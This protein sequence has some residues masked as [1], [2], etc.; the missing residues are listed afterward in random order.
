MKRKARLPLRWVVYLLLVTLLATGVSLSRYATTIAGS[1]SV[2][3]ARPVVEY[4][5]GN[6]TGDPANFKPGDTLSYT[7]SVRNY[8]ASGNR[9]QVTMQYGVS[10][11]LKAPAAQAFPFSR[12]LY[13]KQGADDVAYPADGMD[14]G[15]SQDQQHD[16]RIIF[17]WPANENGGAYMNLEQQLEVVVAASQVD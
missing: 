10:V 8:D 7:F 14:L 16:Y 12:T 17:D 13:L 6:W 9:T 15:H 5:P 1:G 3:V 4:L 2:S 11:A